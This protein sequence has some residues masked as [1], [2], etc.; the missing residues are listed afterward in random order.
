MRSENPG[1]ERV[2]SRAKLILE[3]Y[4]LQTDLFV[5]YFSGLNTDYVVLDV[6]CGDGYHLEILRNLGFQSIY[7]IDTDE[8]MLDLAAEKGLNVRY[9]DLY[10]LEIQGVFDVIL[11]CDLLGHLEDPELALS[12]VHTALKESGILYLTVPV[13]ESLAE[14][15][16]RRKRRTHPGSMTSQQVIY[17]L[18]KS[19]FEPEH[20]IR[21]ANRLPLSS[22]RVQSLTFGGRFGNWLIV[23]ARKIKP[24]QIPVG[25]VE[26]DED[27]K[28]VR[29]DVEGDSV[30]G[31][32]TEPPASA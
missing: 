3:E 21:T 6:A 15:L 18:E 12:R 2:S 19:G 10:E 9:G 7:G 17:L 16:A 22:G 32:D 13:Y 23:I 30:G 25:E 28:A 26:R 27:V 8:K 4:K 1:G 29:Q 24:T 20:K 31:G 14:K 5:R 11:M